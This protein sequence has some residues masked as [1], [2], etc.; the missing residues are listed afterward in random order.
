MADGIQPARICAQ[1][2]YELYD[3]LAYLPV[4]LK[5]ITRAADTYHLATRVSASTSNATMLTSGAKRRGRFA[6]NHRLQNHQRR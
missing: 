6:G 1:Q 4:D 3:V 5:S 2:V